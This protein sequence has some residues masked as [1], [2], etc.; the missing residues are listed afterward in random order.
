MS[1]Q[2]TMPNL[3]KLLDPNHYLPLLPDLKEKLNSLKTNY[4]TYQ[5][6]IHRDSLFAICHYTISMDGS[7]IVLQYDPEKSKKTSKEKK[8]H[9]EPSLLDCPSIQAVLKQFLK[10]IGDPTLTRVEV[11]LIQTQTFP[12]V[13]NPHRDSQFWRLRHIQ[14][15][16]TVLISSGGIH[17][18][19]MQLFHSDGDQLGPFHVIETL[20]T[21]PGTGYIVY[22]PPHKIFHGMKSAFE[23]TEDAHRAAL[24]LRF[25]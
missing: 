20:P 5:K 9:T 15:L 2:N 14:Y 3:Y 22:E 23:D 16:A 10:D 4:V 24:L 19:N 21:L 8:T 6:E 7:N 12:F 18:G 11:K 17:G 1:S 13:F 25:F